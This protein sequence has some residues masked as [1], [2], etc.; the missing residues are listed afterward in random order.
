MAEPITWRTLT[1]PN[2]AEFGRPFA[3][4]QQGISGAFDALKTALT[5]YQKGEETIWK[6]QDADAT[7][8]RLAQIY[9]TQTPGAVDA[10]AQSGV[11]K[12]N[13]DPN[14][15]QI[16]LAEV[17]KLYDG[18]KEV[19]QGREQKG[20]EYAEAE[21]VKRE[22][23]LMGQAKSL[24]YSNKPEDAFKVIASA[25]SQTQGE[26]A[27]LA[28]AH[29][30]TLAQRKRTGEKH[31]SD[32][33]RVTAEMENWKESRR[34]QEI[35][36]RASQDQARASLTSAG[37]QVRQAAVAEGR[38]LLDARRA[39]ETQLAGVNQ[40]ITD[41]VQLGAPIA[42][43]AGQQYVLKTL[44][45]S[46]KDPDA[47]NRLTASFSELLR[48]PK[49]QG[50]SASDVATA[51]IGDISTGSSARKFF[52][53]GTGDSVQSIL[54]KTPDSSSSEQAKARE[55]AIGDYRK[56]ATH[57]KGQLYPNLQTSNAPGSNIPGSAL[58]ARGQ[59]TGSNSGQESGSFEA[60]ATS[61]LTTD[62]SK[63]R[64]QQEDV[65]AGVRSAV[66][67]A[68]MKKVAEDRV[69]GEAA[70]I[71]QEEELQSR[72]IEAAK[73]AGIDVVPKPDERAFRAALLNSTVG[74]PIADRSRAE[75]QRYNYFIRR[76][77][78]LLAN[79]KG[80]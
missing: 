2:L 3:F 79:Q 75:I 60:S 53:N 19:V 11:L 4:A 71:R 13:T 1:A 76:T 7:Q 18:R 70:A 15:P 23:P 43:E 14:G 31:D 29:I 56:I 38:A 57:L 6:K 5:D 73:K 32:I 48:D 68:L 39:D 64:Q 47:L 22:A 21:R 17:F 27:N 45:A 41:L 24:L 42:S 55:Q 69:A 59:S 16:N 28:Q 37:A 50:R 46:V 51:L 36:A 65:K 62:I 9:A 61:S 10:L 77:D 67:P 66:D 35:Q 30:E 20:W 58:P 26:F 49:Y 44:A 8:A 63:L 52:W 72:R 33:A 34:I 25:S 78:E 40:K 74:G 12:Q 80:R 54:D